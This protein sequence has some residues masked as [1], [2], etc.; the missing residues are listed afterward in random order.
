MRTC[1]LL[2]AAVV[3]FALAAGSGRSEPV[4]KVAPNEATEKEFARFEGTWKFVSLEVGGKKLPPEALKGHSLILKGDRFEMHTEEGVV[5]GTFK[6][7]VA[8]K[9]K[10]IDITFT[11]GPPKG[12]TLKGIYKLEDDTYTVCIDPAAK[13]RVTEFASKPGTMGV[14]EV[15]KRE[16]AKKD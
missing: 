12:Q 7:D 16:K 9:P 3:G 2:V 5:K 6:V 1:A 14:L 15:L 13:E 10:Q 11:D 8:T 4:K